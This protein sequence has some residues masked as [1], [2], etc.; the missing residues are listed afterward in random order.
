MKQLACEMCGSTDLAKENG[1]VVC[2]SCGMKY[3][4]EEAKKLMIEGTVEVTGTVAVDKTKEA[5]ALLKRAFM[6]LSEGDWASVNKYCDMVLDI[7]PENAQAYLGK[8]MA[9]LGVQK[10]EDIKNCYEDFRSN[11][12]F[13]KAMLYAD[14]KLKSTLNSYTEYFKENIAPILSQLESFEFS[15]YTNRDE[16]FHKKALGIKVGEVNT[17]TIRGIK[18][19]T[20][21]H[22]ELPNCINYI[23]NSAFKNC[24]NLKNVDIPDSVTSIDKDTFYGCS[25]LTSITIPDSVTN[26]GENAFYGCSG[27]ENITI[28]NSVTSIGKCAFAECKNL[29]CITIP[30]SVT[31]IGGHAFSGCTNLTN[32]TIPDS[33]T[34][35]GDYAFQNCSSFTSITIPNGIS[36][37]SNTFRGCTNLK[38]VTLP[39]SVTSIS[40]AF[41]ECTSLTG[42]KIPDSVTSIGTAF[43]DCRSLTSITIPDGV[44]KIVPHAFSGCSSLE[45]ITI[46][47]S[48]TCIGNY[49]FKDCSSLKK[50]YITDIEA[51]CKICYSGYGCYPLIGSADLYL[52]GELVTDLVIPDGVTSIG[53]YAFYGYSFLKSITIPDSVTTIG[54]YAFYRCSN[55][56]NMTIGSGVT[57]V[58]TNALYATNLNSITVGKEELIRYLHNPVTASVTFKTA[59]G[60]WKT[61]TYKKY[62]KKYLGR[63]F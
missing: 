2:Q 47:A 32:I 25:S 6:F 16:V 44:T 5:E 55:L 28:P 27:I 19:K 20:I 38:K 13:K 46:P 56:T 3:S 62:A 34:T 57:S 41:S 39:N 58:G 59:K 9:D 26:I 48:V 42:I 40:G 51:W 12:Y 30:D 17:I 33:V 11:N 43:Y 36:I 60:T 50:I 31:T 21:E 8:L 24:T 49:A 45:N 18:D 29:T 7:D 4:V 15:I 61:M 35:I 63:Y 1:F 14:D 37:L 10:Q 22:V 53:K 23:S 54:D 52:N